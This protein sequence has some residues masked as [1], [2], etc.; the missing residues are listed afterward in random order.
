MTRPPPAPESVSGLRRTA[1][2]AAWLT[3]GQVAGQA[4]ALIRNI[5]IARLLAPEYFG[6]AATLAM[7]S[8]LLESISHVASD[9]LIVQSRD[10]AEPRL[11]ATAHCVQAI[12]GLVLA[13]VAAL[14]AWPLARYFNATEHYHAYLAVASVPVVRGLAHLGI[15]VQQRSLRF[16]PTV[17]SELAGH[18]CALTLAVSLTP[19]LRTP[20]AMAWVL[21]GQAAAQTLVT[22]LV[23]GQPY[24]WALDASAL[25]ALLSFGWPLMLNGA[26]MFFIMEGDR[27][28]VGPFY[29]ATALGW[30]GAALVLSVAP[31]AALVRV[32]AGIG[33]PILARNRGVPGMFASNVALLFGL[34]AAAAGAVGVGFT[35][36]APYLAT[37]LYG[38]AFAEAGPLIA[39]YG[40]VQSLRLLRVP[41][42][43]V[44]M[45]LGDTRNTLVANL[46]RLLGLPAA[47]LL[48]LQGAPLIAIPIA[49]L[50][51]ELLAG[52]VSAWL[53]LRQYRISPAISMPPTVTALVALGCAALTSL[54]AADWN[55]GIAIAFAGVSAVAASALIALALSSPR[56]FIL[57]A[58]SRLRGLHRRSASTQP[59]RRAP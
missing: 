19:A 46:V 57:H 21:I 29:G 54:W 32:V 47:Y 23:T 3:T 6:I 49:A 16:G 7:A 38:E 24:R 36:A 55:A 8:S 15:N 56:A 33:L 39:V 28:I 51:A 58:V 13:V 37:S 34:T 5:I 12:R 41:S 9:R 2:G 14:A 31:S 40:A 26:V 4:L 44:A 50:V 42:A 20:M 25:R 11:L 45:S 43:L 1:S 10:G 17:T 48:A 52:L 18:V 22:F 27:F 59:L 53:L 35:I 30:I